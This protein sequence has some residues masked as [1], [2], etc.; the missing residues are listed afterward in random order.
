M[1]IALLSACGGGGG[2]N[3]NNNASNNTSPPPEAS[4]VKYADLIDILLPDAVT[5][6]DPHH[7]G[8]AGTGHRAVFIC[9][10]DRLVQRTADGDFL[11][12]LATSW[13]TDDLQTWTFNLR[14]DVT[15]HNGQKF[16]AQDVIDTME[17]GQQSP[18]TV[19]YNAWRDIDTITALDDYTVQMVLNTVNADFLFFVSD[20]GAS[21]IN[22]AARAADPVS[23]AYVGTGAYYVDNFVSGEYITLT[24]ND[25]YW[26]EAPKTRQLNFRWVPEM[27]ARTIMLQNGETDFGWVVTG[28]DV[29]GFESDPANF[30]I[31]RFTGNACFTLA[32]NLNDSITGDLNFRMAVAHAMNLPDIG[33]AAE[34]TNAVI[35]D[36][37]TFWGY[38]TAFRNSDIPAIPYD[39]ELAKQYL[40][41]SSYNG[42]EVEIMAALPPNIKA[43]EMMVEQLS[44]VGIKATLFI[45]D[46]AN[47]N[48]V[49]GYG[50]DVTQMVITVSP[51]DA[52]AASARNYLHPEGSGNRSNYNNARVNELF[53]LAPTVADRGQ[54]EAIYR[55]IQE[56]VHGDLPKINH[57]YLTFPIV[58]TSALRGFVTDPDQNH[59]LRLIYKVIED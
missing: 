37:G 35:Q 57:F 12:E 6:P 28:E 24:R 18:G 34:G 15:F 56:V 8:G 10:F 41:D 7:T 36:D 21:I 23:G 11:P 27:T 29:P 49:A 51:F 59:D 55:E 43:G 14:N 31:Y 20:P 58:T 40:A 4:G 26:G 45:T 46:I 47:L 39:P 13:E 52:N 3:T 22:K 1:A 25:D 2:G 32:F 53:D 42:E 48:A 16:T 19:G 30:S 5:T 44:A 17:S 54:R 50:N 9:I 38:K 33:M